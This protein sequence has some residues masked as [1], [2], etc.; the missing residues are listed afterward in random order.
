MRRNKGNKKTLI[1]LASVFTV[2]LMLSS[3]VSISAIGFKSARDADVLSRASEYISKEKIKREEIVSAASINEKESSEAVSDVEEQSKS[4]E[5]TAANSAEEEITEESSEVV[6][7]ADSAKEGSE[8]QSSKGDEGGES[9]DDGQVPPIAPD[10]GESVSYE[11]ESSEESSEVVSAADSAKEGSELQSAEKSKSSSEKAVSSEGCP[12]CAQLASEKVSEA[13][14]ASAK[15]VPDEEKV[16]LLKNKIVEILSA[17]NSLD[18]A[19]DGIS[20]SIDIDDVNIEAER[21]MSEIVSSG[22]IDTMFYKLSGFNTATSSFGDGFWFCLWKSKDTIFRWLN[23]FNCWEPSGSSSYSIETSS[24]SSETQI[25]ESSESLT[26][27]AKSIFINTALLSS[28]YNQVSATEQANFLDSISNAVGVY[29]TYILS[30][31][32]SENGQPHS[33]LA[34]I[35]NNGLSNTE[36]DSIIDLILNKLPNSDIS[37]EDVRGAIISTL[38]DI[39]GSSLTSLLQGEYGQTSSGVGFNSGMMAMGGAMMMTGGTATNGIIGDCIKAGKDATQEAF[40]QYLKDIGVLNNTTG[41]SQWNI[42]DIGDLFYHIGNTDWTVD[43]EEYESPL[44]YIQMWIESFDENC[45]I[46]ETIQSFIDGFNQNIWDNLLQHGENPEDY[47]LDG[48]GVI[49][50]EEGKSI[51]GYWA[52]GLGGGSK[53]LR[54]HCHQNNAAAAAAALAASMASATATTSTTTTTTTTST[55]QIQQT[56]EMTEGTMSYGL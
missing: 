34:N 25:Q 51:H 21:A 45:E 37:R 4:E 52:W 56:T 12:Y 26:E 53:G 28:Y 9:S 48:D 14:L 5:E 1:I 3:T 38:N 42:D 36:I 32:L 8:L 50:P 46:D 39:G 43:P 15:D 31:V 10:K 16:R 40:E 7:A 55:T 6:S 22:E 18:F 35:V 30:S 19:E 17:M 41:E 47:D 20:I 29:D 27:S 23:F 2:I 49:S 11:K 54:Q 13:E 33:S 24:V 44:P